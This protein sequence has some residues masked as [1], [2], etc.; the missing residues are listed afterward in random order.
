MK[1]VSTCDREWGS[2]LTMISGD[3]ALSLEFLDW[4]LGR[5]WE[6]KDIP[7]LVPH[8]NTVDAART[9]GLRGLGLEHIQVVT[10]RHVSS[11]LQP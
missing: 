6:E 3:V 8:L 7:I 5:L 1:V 10:S 4:R 11:V 2:L 9:Q